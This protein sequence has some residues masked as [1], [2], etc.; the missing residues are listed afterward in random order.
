M[1]TIS[2][3]SIADYESRIVSMRTKFKALLSSASHED[4][5]KEVQGLLL[6]ASKIE[7]ISRKMRH[8]ELI[9]VV[10]PLVSML[11]EIQEK[12]SALNSDSVR[13]IALVIDYLFL[14]TSGE[15]FERDWKSDRKFEVLVVD[16][17]SLSLRATS[18]A[19]ENG[20]FQVTSSIEPMEG[21]QLIDA[22]KWD[23]ILLDVEMPDISGYEMCSRVRNSAIQSGTPVVFVT[24]NTSAEARKT[25][26]GEGGN[27]LVSKP[28]SFPELVLKCWTWIFMS[29]R[30]STSPSATAQA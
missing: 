27:D 23:L 22:K 13:S 28:F 17:E 25:C 1:S 19:L 29:L 16:D 24:G 5:I 3:E 15:G 26:I 18:F 2:Q 21:A 8:G 30:K 20:E 12:P 9:M 14:L 6:D 4:R 11:A 10:R 7:S